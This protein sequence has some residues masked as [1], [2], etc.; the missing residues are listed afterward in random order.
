MS[1][2]TYEDNDLLD[3]LLAEPA[4]PSPDELCGR[5]EETPSARGLA[6]FAVNEA[7]TFPAPAAASRD[8][9]S[10]RRL[11]VDGVRFDHPREDADA[12]D[13][14]DINDVAKILALPTQKKLQVL[15]SPLSVEDRVKVLAFMAETRMS[16]DDPAFIAAGLMGLIGAVGRKIPA[17]V[18]S[19]GDSAVENIQHAMTAYAEVPQAISDARDLLKETVAEAA[20]AFEEASIRVNDAFVER[21]RKDLGEDL[22][23]RE[24]ARR[25]E[26]EERDAELARQLELAKRKIDE[27]GERAENKLAVSISKWVDIAHTVA[28]ARALESPKRSGSKSAETLFFK[29]GQAPI[30]ALAFGAGALFIALILTAFK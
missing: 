28:S 15:L 3:Q 4:A 11:G 24:Q 2:E 26:S 21:L 27:F 6:P 18:V 19:A 20:G 13:M 7:P 14:A 23:A 5:T 17:A 8:R 1:A 29:L 16:P 25:T 10:T 22:Y 9:E 12:I 30:A